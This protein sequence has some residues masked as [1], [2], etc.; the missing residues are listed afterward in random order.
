[1]KKAIL[2][3][4]LTTLAALP[5]SA[6]DESATVQVT[7]PAA[8]RLSDIKKVFVAP[9]GTDTGAEIIRQKII[10]RLIKDGTIA[11]V[12]T[13]DNADATLVG[14]SEMSHNGYIV[15][16]NG[17]ASSGT[18]YHADSALR[19][20]GRDKQLL[21]MD[22]IQSRKYFPPHSAKGASSNLADKV[23]KRLVDAIEAD[24]LQI[25]AQ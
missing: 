10:N 8:Q 23:V 2:L 1:M 14:A 25:A 3:L 17:F 13:A 9:L 15:V 18:K 16:N 7:V 4:A 22:E 24:K 19:L 12:E 6:A 21:W 5:V 11:V 20:L